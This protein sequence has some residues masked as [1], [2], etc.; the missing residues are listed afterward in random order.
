MDRITRTTTSHTRLHL[1]TAVSPRKD[2]GS[3]PTGIVGRSLARQLLDA[4]D[5]VRV[6]AEPARW[7]LDQRPTVREII[8]RPLRGFDEWAVENAQLFC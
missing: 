3:S 7:T 5:R 6:L 1:L 2:A 8:G 4:G